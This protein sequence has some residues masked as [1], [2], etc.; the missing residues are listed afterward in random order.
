MKVFGT[1]GVLVAILRYGGEHDRR[2]YPELRAFIL[3]NAVRGAIR[4]EEPDMSQLCW[5][6]PSSVSRPRARWIQAA[7]AGG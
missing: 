5:V 4:T 3:S 1:N 7:I 6:A 2:A